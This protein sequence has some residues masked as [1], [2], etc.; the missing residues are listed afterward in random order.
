VVKAITAIPRTAIKD[1][2]AGGGAVRATVSRGAL[3]SQRMRYAT[4]RRASTNFIQLISGFELT[5]ILATKT[6]MIQVLRARDYGVL[7]VSPAR[8]GVN[9]GS[10]RARVA[11]SKL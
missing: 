10:R 7:I 1:S 2:L 4:P 6:F 3:A 9:R 8:G 5:Q 11:C